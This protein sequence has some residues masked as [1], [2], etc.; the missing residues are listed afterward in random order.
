[1]AEKENVNGQ[2]VAPDLDLEDVINEIVQPQQI[3]GVLERLDVLVQQTFDEGKKAGRQWAKLDYWS[4][5]AFAVL[6]VANLAIGIAGIVWGNRWW[7]IGLSFIVAGWMGWEVWR[8][9]PR[10]K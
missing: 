3:R 7:T 4:G 9:R 6:A 2:E 10:T 1:M 8:K 5:V